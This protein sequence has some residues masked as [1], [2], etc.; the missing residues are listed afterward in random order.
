MRVKDRTFLQ[1]S[2]LGIA[3]V[4]SVGRANAQAGSAG[5]AYG[6]DFDAVDRFWPVYELLSRDRA[7]SPNN[8]RDA[9][10]YAWIQARGAESGAGG[11]RGS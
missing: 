11:A 6:V 8:G 10:L 3:L 4:A 1:G 9:A 2:V 7:P 5:T